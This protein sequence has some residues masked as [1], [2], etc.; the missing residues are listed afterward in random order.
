MALSLAACGGSDDVAVDLTPFA[1]S[2]IDSAVATANEAAAAT[3]V[4]VANAAATAQAEAVAAAEAAIDI[5]SNDAAVIKVAVETALTAADGIEY[6]TVDSA[7][8]A[9]QSQ[10]VS[11]AV[12]AAEAAI[13]G[14]YADA[15]ALIESNDAAVTATATDAAEATLLAGT[16]FATVAA[17]KAA[18]DTA[19][20]AENATY[21][22][23]ASSTVSDAYT[24]G[25]GVDEITATS[26]SLQAGDIIIGGAGV[27][28]L[29]VSATGAVA[30]ATLI[31]S[32]ETVT[33]NMASFAAAA[34]DVDNI[35]DYTTMTINNTQTGGLAA[36]NLD[37][38]EAGGT[39]VMG[40]GVTGAVNIDADG[41]AIFNIG[42]GS[43][44][45]M[46]LNNVTATSTITAN[47]VTGGTGVTT[48]I[49]DIELTKVDSAVIQSTSAAFIIVSGDADTTDEVTI[50]AANAS[51][52]AT[53]GLETALAAQVENI[54][55]SGNGGAATYALDGDDAPESITLTGDQNVKLQLTS[56]QLTTETV[57]DTTSADATGSVVIT[58][59]SAAT[60]DFGNVDTLI[61]LAH[62]DAQ[63][64]VYD[65]ANGASLRISADAGALLTVSSDELS[66]G[67]ETA[68]VTLASSQATQA[69]VLSDFETLNLIVDDGLAAKNTITL[70]D[71][72][73][74]ASGTVNIS[75]GDNLTL[76]GADAKVVNASG[77]TGNL[78][79]TLASDLN[80][81]TGGDGADIFT[82]ATEVGF[83]VAGGEGNDT[84]KIDE[85]DT[86]N[87][88][89]D[90]SGAGV[91]ISGIDV[92][93]LDAADADND[94]QVII[95]SSDISGQ[96]IAITGTEG[97]ASTDEDILYVKADTTTVDLSNL[98][99]D[100]AN[101]DVTID[102]TS[103]QGVSTVIDGTNA[104]DTLS[105]AGAGNVTF[106]GHDGADV[107][108][109]ST[110]TD[111]VDGG[112]G[113]DTISTGAG[114]DNITAGAGIDGITSGDGNDT[115]DLTEATAAVDTLNYASDDGAADVDTVTGFNVGT[116]D[117]LISVD[118][119]ATTTALTVG[120]ATGSAATA[121]GSVVVTSHAVDT[122]LNIATGTDETIIKLT[123]AG[124]TFADAIGSGAITV[125]D[126]AVISFTW[127]DSDTGEAVYGYSSEA[128]ANDASNVI[129]DADTFVEIVRIELTSA[130]YETLGTDNFVLV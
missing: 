9:A 28:T 112:A 21:E 69:T 88:E 107:I 122:A 23:S 130:D 73:A 56:A 31:S 6:P 41:A 49:A 115:I 99:V 25:S 24:G 79:A 4:T 117:D 13:L 68:T 27:D 114:D 63:A 83:S 70:F 74:T 26:T 96:A 65:V 43:N 33:I 20:L 22:V 108:T 84:L 15:T 75:G 82:I 89:T 127:Y 87:N 94:L 66:S 36:V 58:A 118:A 116:V 62:T 8:A 64:I 12:A 104:I 103:V 46:D 80:D 106:N 7:I 126:A 120:D 19:T 52:T 78:T 18:Y 95:L 39:V 42:S 44:L 105:N 91:S 61:D 54:T 45:V 81:V 30:A 92:I 97:A 11:E 3:A 100:V 57:T 72:N 113:D 48:G 86:V 50:S 35:K 129:D 121:A 123:A 101:V 124:S 16:G 51:A 53:I 5:E 71:L 14:D 10:D 29:T 17:L 109:T 59:A 40:A 38:V 76:T 34:I 125:A 55:L 90:L 67:N 2:D 110:G 93:T 60:A 102:I 119:D 111:I 128:S 37:N 77:L 47:S 98:V 32:V 1:Q 85:A